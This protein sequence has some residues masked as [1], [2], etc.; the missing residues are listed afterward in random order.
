V[1][2][3]AGVAGRWQRLGGGVQRC[4]CTR[5]LKQ[6]CVLSLHCERALCGGNTLIKLGLPICYMLSACAA[7]A[8]WC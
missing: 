5:N 7:A 3:A 8:R 2:Q 4:V 6:P 1:C